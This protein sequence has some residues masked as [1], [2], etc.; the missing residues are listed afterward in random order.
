MTAKYDVLLTN[1]IVVDPAH[2]RTGRFDLAMA[3]GRIAAVAE[4]LDPAHAGETIDLDGATVVPGIIDLHVHVSAWLGGRFGHRMMARAGVTTALDVSG[5]I[6]GVVDVARHHGAGLNLGCVHY[7]RPG[8]TVAGTDPGTD[9]LS[10]LL[11]DC[12]GKGALGFKIL[13]GHYPMTP[14]ATARTIAVA[15]ARGAYIAFH[16]GTLATG[17]NI[18]GVV[19]AFDLADG[20][21]M[22]LAHV[23]SYCRGRVH[24]PLEEAATAISLLEKNPTVCSESYLAVINGTSAKCSDGAPESNA[25]KGSL[26]EG[27]FPPTERGMEDAIVAGWALVNMEDEDEIVLGSGPDAVAWWRASGTDV[28]VC[29]PVNPPEPRL[30]LATAKRSS[31]AFAVDCLATDGGGIPRNE[32]VENGLALVRLGALTIDEFALKASTNPARIL[33]LADKGHLGVGADADVTVLDVV[34]LRPVM[35]FANGRPVLRDGEV[36]GSGTRMITTP[37]GTDY[38]H[39]A[40][41]DTL[42][43][44]PAETPICR[45]P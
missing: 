19:E 36:V 21:F 13:G 39:Q 41:L 30:H 45:R 35:S 26:A 9:E 43:V 22:H 15:N 27:N 31:G 23:N 12:M 7:V 16:A 4:G 38:V 28:T 14:E 29:F 32:T 20:H 6:E 8:H 37:A 24:P 42:I 5:P 40:G 1:G 25:T 17:S 18:D 44:D 2:G 10:A 34:R 33:A 3:G 11:D